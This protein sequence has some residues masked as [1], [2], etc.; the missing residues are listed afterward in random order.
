MPLVFSG[1]FHRVIMQSGSALDSWAFHTAED[2]RDNGVAVAKL[3][4]CQS[5]DSRS[6][7]DFL[8]SQPALDLL[9]PQEQIVAAA[10]V[11]FTL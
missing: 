9:K 3:L 11:N 1:L 8:K 4:G 6:V 5:E 7:L 10:A 2:N